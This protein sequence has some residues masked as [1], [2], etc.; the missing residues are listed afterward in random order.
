[1]LQV[2][3]I[4]VFYGKIKAL[5]SVSLSV[6]ADEIVCLIGANGAGKTTT[7]MAISSVLRPA[8]GKITFDGRDVARMQAEDVVRAGIAQVPEGRRIFPDLTVQENLRMGAFARADRK[9]YGDD[10]ARVYEL[11]PRLLERRSQLGGT[12]SGGEQ[13]MLAIGRAL[14]SRPKLL[15]LDEPSLG[16]APIIVERVFEVIKEI[17]KQGTAILLV[18]QN[19]FAALNLAHRGY[20]LETGNTVLAGAAKDLLADQQVR[21]AYLG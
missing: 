12:L 8:E 15:L 7:L 16:L 9:R 4:S 6:N 21:Q 19:A 18:E 20:V 2:E 10:L 5:K 17:N 13:Q 3:A 11:F 14:M 1:M